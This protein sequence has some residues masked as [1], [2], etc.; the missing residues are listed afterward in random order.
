MAEEAEARAR[1]G[2]APRRRRRPSRAIASQAGSPSSSV[3]VTVRYGMRARVNAPASSGTQQA[4]QFASH[5]PVVIA[6]VVERAGRLQVEDHDRRLRRLHG[7][8]HL[9]RGRVG[10]RVEQHQLDRPAASSVAR[11]ARALGRVD[12]AGRDD[13]G[14][15]LRRA[16]PRA[17][18]GSP[19]AAR[20]APRTAASRR[21]GRSRRRRPAASSASSSAAASSRRRRARALRSLRRAAPVEIAR[22]SARPRSR[23]A[24][25]R[26]RC[27]G[28]APRSGR[29]SSTS[30]GSRGSP[31]ASTTPMIVPRP[32]KIEMPP[33][34]TIVTTS[35]SCPTPG[36]VAGRGE[37]E[38]PEDPREAAQHAG[39]HEEPELDPL[40]RGCPAKNAASCPAPIAIDRPPERRRV[41]DDAEDDRE[42][43][44]EER[45]TTAICVP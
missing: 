23:S 13:V 8:Q 24:G 18:A 35:S 25:R 1:A 29:A 22:R 36:V 7:G 19:R 11:L 41:Q 2:C 4:E 39:E 45:P 33:S 12:E 27:S 37:P 15:E 16:S 42:D 31:T 6:L 34:S 26:R 9:R 44:E 40:A 17:R 5:S 14:A 30:A 38:R 10:R 3:P 32:P 21:R 28:P 43:R 20:A